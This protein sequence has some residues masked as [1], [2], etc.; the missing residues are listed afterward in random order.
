MKYEM[1]NKKQRMHTAADQAAKLGNI[2]EQG[3]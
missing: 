3:A 1:L 2:Q